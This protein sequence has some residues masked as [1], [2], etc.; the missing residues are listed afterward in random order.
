[1]E[2]LSSTAFTRA[3]SLALTGRRRAAPHDAR[4]HAPNRHLRAH[5]HV[6][7]GHPSRSKK[8]QVKSLPTN[9]NRM[10]VMDKL[11]MWGIDVERMRSGSKGSTAPAG[12]GGEGE[13]E[14]GGGSTATVRRAAAALNATRAAGTTATI[15]AEEGSA[16]SSSNPTAAGASRSQSQSSSG[17]EGVMGLGK[18]EASVAVAMAMQQNSEAKSGANAPTSP[19]VAAMLAR[20]EAEHWPAQ[21][22]DEWLLARCRIVSASEAASALGVDSFRTPERLIRDKL[23]RLDALEGISPAVLEAVKAEMEAGGGGGG[24]GGSASSDLGWRAKG[25]KGKKKKKK[26]K[27]GGAGGSRHRV[28]PGGVGGADGPGGRWRRL[29][30]PVMHGNAYEPV[31]RAH[32]AAAEGETVHDFGLKI[33]DE[34]AW[35]GASP[36]GVTAAG[37]VLEIK[38]PYSR[39]VL[40]NT[41]ANAGGC[42]QV[43][44]IVFNLECRPLCACTRG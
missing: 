44:A 13:G 29:P 42:T 1:M 40:P 20:Q 41:R 31:A 26:K 28:S 8:A 18:E 21:G 17:E 39:P 11:L 7:A 15:D 5:V 4:T 38:C 37:R 24:R 34:L 6:Y 16:S 14:G 3:S 25:V 33:H 22:G 35:L 23:A 19:K 9:P 10:A 43:V 32:Y 12:G 30:P 27:K 2:S 36:D